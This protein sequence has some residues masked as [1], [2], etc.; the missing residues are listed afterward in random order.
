MVLDVLLSKEHIDDNNRAVME[1]R[2]LNLTSYVPVS[3]DNLRQGHMFF[4]NERLSKILIEN[5]TSLMAIACTYFNLS[6]ASH[7]TRYLVEIVY[8][9]EY[10]ELYHLLYFLPDLENFFKLVGIDVITTPFGPLIKPPETFYSELMSQGLDYPFPYPFYNYSFHSFDA[11]AAKKKE[12]N[13]HIT[14]YIDITLKHE[15]EVAQ[16]KERQLKNTESPRAI[17]RGSKMAQQVDSTESSED[18]FDNDDEMEDDDDD[19]DDSMDA[20]DE[21]QA[22]T[23]GDYGD[24]VN[25]DQSSKGIM[26]KNEAGQ[27]SFAIIPIDGRNFGDDKKA[28]NKSGVIHQCHLIDPLSNQTCLKIF[29]GKNELLRHQEFV[30]ATKKKIYKCIYCSQNGNKVQSYPRHDSLARHIRRKHGITGRDNKMAVNYAKANV[31]II[32]ESRPNNEVVE[33]AIE[34]TMPPREPAFTEHPAW[35]FVPEPTIEASPFSKFLVR[36]EEPGQI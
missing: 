32:D 34:P 7:I 24:H 28:K 20:G 13:I 22:Y 19:N 2:L 8:A 26:V 11:N 10:W 35:K 15:E 1:N 23:A 3:S 6:L 4:P 5:F 36:R 29:Y 12:N 31:E 14:P 30:H 9:L 17:T 27:Q 33:S 25:F 21:Y 16:A 18:N